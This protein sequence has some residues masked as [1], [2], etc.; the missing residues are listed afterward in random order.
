MQRGTNT[1]VS[2][3]TTFSMVKGLRHGLTA[4]SLVVTMLKV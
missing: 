4:Q 1:L 3:E 2:G